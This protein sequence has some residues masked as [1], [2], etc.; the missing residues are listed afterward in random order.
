MLLIT[1][2]YFLITTVS[3]ISFASENNRPIKPSEDDF[4]IPPPDFESAP[5]GKIVRKR[6]VPH[7]LT[8]VFT[9]MKVQNA[10]HIMVR[11]EDSFNEPNVIVATIIKPFNANPNKLISYQPFEDSRNPDCAPSYAIQFGSNINTLI[12]QSEMVNVDVMLKQGY[13]VVIPDYQGPEGAY[14]AGRQAGY[15]VLNSLTATLT[16]K[17]FT[18]INHDADTILM[19]YSGGT[20]ASGWAAMLQ[21]EYAPHLKKNLIGA[22]LGAFT[23]NIT[24]MVEIVDGTLF[25]GLIPNVLIGLSNQYPKLKKFYWERLNP[26]LADKFFNKAQ[27]FFDALI[28]WIL[29]S[30]FKGKNTFFPGGISILREEPMRSI[31]KSNNIVDQSKYLVPNIPIF[32]YHGSLDKVVPIKD[33]FKSFENWCSLG[34]KSG[35]FVEDKSSGHSVLSLIGIAIARPWIIQ[36]MNGKPPV[37]GCV[38]NKQLTTFGYPKTIA[39]FYK[40]S[41]D[42]LKAMTGFK[43]GPK[44]KSLENYDTSELSNLKQFLQELDDNKY[45]ST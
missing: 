29:T 7:R 40:N 15:A 44:Y 27:C 1:I 42:M 20:I 6:E 31:L 10:W 32:I 45:I 5:V 14:T 26:D 16:T 23:T 21:P 24:S 25:A 37:N 30:F 28:K 43:L 38:H 35:E 4:Y 12:T 3:A 33:S 36:R 2:Y 19:G 11:S 41:I 17:K 13:Y 9:P 22:V 8:N 34:L 39:A 18:G